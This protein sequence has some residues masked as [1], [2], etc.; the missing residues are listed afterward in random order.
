MTEGRKAVVLKGVEECNV[1]LPKLFLNLYK[2][3]RKVPPG[4]KE[5]ISRWL[6]VLEALSDIFCKDVPMKLDKIE[7]PG[8]L[9]GLVDHNEKLLGLLDDAYE[10]IKKDPEILIGGANA[11]PWLSLPNGQ[12]QSVFQKLNLL[13]Y[14]F[15]E[16]LS[17][18][19]PPKRKSS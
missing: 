19:E 3:Y 7:D 12:L 6:T 18:P 16:S 8:I 1:I 14:A 4:G 13:L 5:K 15:K 11:G 17:P 9:D 10:S 2:G